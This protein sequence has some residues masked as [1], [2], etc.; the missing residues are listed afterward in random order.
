MEVQLSPTWFPASTFT[1]LQFPSLLQPEF[2][3]QSRTWLITPPPPCWETI[4]ESPLSTQFLFKIPHDQS[5]T[6]DFQL[7]PLLPQ[8]YSTQTELLCGLTFTFSLDFNELPETSHYLKYSPMHSI[9]SVMPS[10]AC[11]AGTL[12]SL[13]HLI[14]PWSLQVHSMFVTVLLSYI[15][16]ANPLWPPGFSTCWK[17]SLLLLFHS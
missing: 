13:W 4:N 16:C 12:A 11:P 15:K 2:S 17:N 7:F 3:S 8:P 6:A 14:S 10:M 1:T 5:W 9:L